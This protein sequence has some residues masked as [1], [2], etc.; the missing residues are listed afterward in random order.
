MKK[1]KDVLKKIAITGLT[2]GMLAAL[3]PMVALAAE[4]TAGTQRES[5]LT[6]EKL[7]VETDGDTA[8]AETDGFSLYTVE[9]TYNN[10]Q[11]VLPGDSEA[12]LSEVLDTVGLTGE[13]SAVE[14]SDESLFSAKKCKASNDGDGKIPEKDGNGNAVEDENGTWFV[15]AHKAFSTE[16]WMKVP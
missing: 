9:F 6:A 13:V 10:K 16:E 3:I 4:G 5:E 8:I 1:F 11:Y 12:A 15:F 14:V 2:A 7:P